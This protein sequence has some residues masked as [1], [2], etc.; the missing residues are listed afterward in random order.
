MGELR[1]PDPTLTALGGMVWVEP[2]ER[3]MV[4]HRY[5]DETEC[6]DGRWLVPVPAHDAAY[7][8]VPCREC[9]DA[10]PAGWRASEDAPMGVD[11]LRL[12]ADPHLAWQV[13][14]TEGASRG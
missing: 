1:A 4:G 7:V 11:G 8:A 9:F 10:P 14:D 3:P 12:V 13:P 2:D 6:D 5:R